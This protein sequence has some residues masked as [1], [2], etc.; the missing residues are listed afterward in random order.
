MCM[1]KFY[2]YTDYDGLRGIVKS[3]EIRMS[4]TGSHGRGV[5]FCRMAP[6]KGRRRIARNNWDGGASRVEGKGRVD[7]AIAVLLPKWK[8]KKYGSIYVFK[9]HVDL[10]YT[11]FKL[12]SKYKDHRDLLDE[13]TDSDTDSDSDTDTDSDSDSDSD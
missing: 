8:V 9:E 1:K 7:Y 2:H 12:Y 5:Y 3:R 10:D 6:E 4:R 13:F 11:D